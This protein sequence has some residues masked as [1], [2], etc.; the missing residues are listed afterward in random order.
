MDGL[1]H[2]RVYAEPGDTFSE[3][4]SL[5]VDL[6]E[7]ESFSTVAVT[8]A[9]RVPRDVMMYLKVGLDSTSY[10]R[11]SGSRWA[12]FLFSSCESFRGGL[13]PCL[14]FGSQCTGKLENSPKES[15][16]PKCVAQTSANN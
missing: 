12:L 8:L 5:G 11:S 10:E 2:F 4:R 3:E 6:E 13:Y 15:K 1:L 9:V 16:Y 14:Q 7:V